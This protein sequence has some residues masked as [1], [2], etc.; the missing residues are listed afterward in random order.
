MSEVTAMHKAEP[1]FSSRGN[2]LKFQRSSIIYALFLFTK[3]G[4]HFSFIILEGRLFR[5]TTVTQNVV[6]VIS[7]YPVIREKIASI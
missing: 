1:F 3:N 5:A 4:K 6:A 2:F 7:Y